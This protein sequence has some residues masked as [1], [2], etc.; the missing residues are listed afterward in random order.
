MSKEELAQKKNLIKKQLALTKLRNLLEDIIE[1]EF[2]NPFM[3]ALP[4]VK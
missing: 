2:Y 4:L 3:R 1:D